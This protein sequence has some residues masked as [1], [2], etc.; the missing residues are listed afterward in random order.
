MK[1]KKMEPRVNRRKFLSAEVVSDKMD[2]TRVVQVRCTAKHDKYQKIMRRSVKYKAHDEK[3][4]SKVGDV[5]KIMETRPLSKD[6][7]WV[8]TEII[9]TS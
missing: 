6:K 5:V 3:N 9:K 7:R 8:I 4:A 1:E 2:K